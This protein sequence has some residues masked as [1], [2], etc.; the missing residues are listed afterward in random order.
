[1]F[2]D[3][4]CVHLIDDLESRYCPP[5]ASYPEDSGDLGHMTDAM[6]YAVYIL[7]PLSVGVVPEQRIHVSLGD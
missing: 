5:G 4:K 6:G 1:M 2:I 7:F 3:P